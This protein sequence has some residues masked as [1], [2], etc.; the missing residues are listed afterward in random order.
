MEPAPSPCLV[1][2]TNAGA[3][4]LFRLPRCT[5]TK[6]HRCGFVY[7]DGERNPAREGRR[8]DWDMFERLGYRLTG[9]RLDAPLKPI[10]HSMHLSYF[11]PGSLRRL[12]ESLGATCGAIVAKE[13][14]VTRFGGGR[15]PLPVRWGIRAVAL[16]D[17]A[18]GTEAKLL[19]AIQRP[20]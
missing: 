15:Y 8:Y 14:H 13:A 9:G 7:I 18:L 12:V 11:T 10:Y 2:Q 19:G 17:K 3:R 4:I 20:M 1:C 5:V 6:C 16:I